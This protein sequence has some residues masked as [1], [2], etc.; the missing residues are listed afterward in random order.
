MRFSAPGDRKLVLPRQ[1]FRR[2]EVYWL[3]T[4]D[5]R[6]AYVIQKFPVP[7]S[8]VICLDSG[9]WEERPLVRCL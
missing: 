9:L 7:P 1:S 3:L 2:V 8:D 6:Q 5:P 4:L